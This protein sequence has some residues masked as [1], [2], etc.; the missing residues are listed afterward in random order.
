MR[1]LLIVLSLAAGGLLV[2]AAQAREEHRS[3]P[4]G[5]VDRGHRAGADRDLRGRPYDVDRGRFRGDRDIV[6]FRCRELV[7]G[8]GCGIRE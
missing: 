6:P 1:H 4:A 5:H 2:V 7:P 3:D 8:I